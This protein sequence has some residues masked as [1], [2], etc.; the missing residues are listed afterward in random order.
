MVV[1]G[2]HVPR[3][4]NGALSRRELPKGRATFHFKVAALLAGSLMEI[5]SC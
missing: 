3:G 4:R 5:K 2:L 1:G